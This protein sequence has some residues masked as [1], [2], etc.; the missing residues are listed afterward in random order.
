MNGW[1]IKYKIAAHET[2]WIALI[3]AAL[4]LAAIGRELSRLYI[5]V[6]WS[7]VPFQG[8]FADTVMAQVWTLVL[9]GMSFVVRAT[10]LLLS[11]P[12]RYS[13]VAFSWLL[14]FASIAFYLWEVLPSYSP[15]TICAEDGQCST[16]YHNPGGGDW[17]AVAG[18]AFVLLSFVRAL[19][20]AAM[21]GTRYR[22]R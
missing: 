12:E 20:T 6:S 7:E 22:Y 4:M 19:I 13:W 9:V 11:K 21:A 15:T 8:D 3:G 18:I 1:L 2:R 14:S 16:M 17:V 5:G 10:F